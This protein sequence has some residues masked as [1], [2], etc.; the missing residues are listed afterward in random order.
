[1]KDDRCPELAS[2]VEF[3]ANA[4]SAVGNSDLE[5]HLVECPRCAATVQKLQR[6]RSR[7]RSYDSATSGPDTIGQIVSA[8]RLERA[9]EERRRAL[10]LAAARWAAVLLVTCA[11]GYGLRKRMT[12]TGSSS[13]GEPAAIHALEKARTWLLDN[14][15]P[16]GS[17]DVEKWGAQGRYRVGVSALA[18]LALAETTNWTER[19]DL[20]RAIERG[21]KYLVSQQTPEGFFGPYGD[22]TPYNHTFATLAL[23][24]VREW[25]GTGAYDPNLGRALEY[26]R[27]SQRPEGSWG[28]PREGTRQPGNA[29]ITLWYVTVLQSAEQLGWREV[30][31]NVDRAF[32]WL[33][34]T[35][36]ERGRV[37]YRRPYDFPWGFESLTA[38][39]L[40]CAATDP[41]GRRVLPL[42]QMREVVSSCRSEFSR[43]YYQ[44]FLLARAFRALE[45][46]Q[47]SQTFRERLQQLSLKQVR[48]G[49]WA[50][51]FHPDDLWSSVGGRV[52]S[53][54]M[55]LLA[56]QH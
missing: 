7:L 4:T 35:T 55:A 3:V 33:R 5:R 15:L 34:T 51:S 13:A 19:P 30:R 17:W 43:D 47:E 18:L 6:I 32:H 11:V 50:G 53:T 20:R 44:A 12:A 23:L 45:Q 31:E 8:V 56:L 37:G 38:A 40:A 14:Q 36:D 52:Y 27:R 48:D 54:A 49:E 41:T 25:W 26:I 22:C 1:M 21:A 46:S 10:S 2:L 39:A 16:D 42:V 28:Y 9:R 29:S 24:R